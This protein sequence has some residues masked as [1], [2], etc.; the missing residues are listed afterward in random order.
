MGAYVLMSVR[1]G[2][3]GLLRK[4]LIGTTF[5]FIDAVPSILG[6][7]WSAGMGFKYCFDEGA[8]PLGESSL[9]YRM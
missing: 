4:N 7:C 1:L 5:P 3:H 8:E 2:Y 6:L 9:R